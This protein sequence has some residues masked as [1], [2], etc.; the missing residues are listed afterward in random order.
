MRT[1]NGG[2]NDGFGDDDPDNFSA[3]IDDLVARADALLRLLAAA[4]HAGWIALPS[5]VPFP[6]D[7]INLN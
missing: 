2:E 5:E 1:I 3:R 6:L 7:S 4:P